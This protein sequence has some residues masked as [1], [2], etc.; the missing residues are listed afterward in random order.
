MIRQHGVPGLRLQR[1]PHVRVVIDALMLHRVARAAE[2]VQEQQRI[3]LGVFDD[4]E[5]QG[6]RL[7]GLLGHSGDEQF[8]SSISIL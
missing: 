1:N 7:K 2:P 5:T 4:E 6:S 3:V 8:E